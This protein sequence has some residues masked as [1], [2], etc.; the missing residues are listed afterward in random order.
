MTIVDK[1][2]SWGNH[3]EYRIM[4]ESGENFFKVKSL[5]VDKM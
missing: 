2:A 4:D 5:V 1:P 3:A